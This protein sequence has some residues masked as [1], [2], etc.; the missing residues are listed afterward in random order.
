MLR[1]LATSFVSDTD[2]LPLPADKPAKW[3]QFDPLARRCYHAAFALFSRLPAACVDRVRT[4][5]VLLAPEGSDATNNAYFADYLENGRELGSGLLFRYTLPSCAPAEVAI[6]FGLQGPL[7]AERAPVSELPTVLPWLDA[8]ATVESLDAVLLLVA[9][10]GRVTGLLFRNEAE[11]DGTHLQTWD[12][13]QLPR[14]AAVVPCYNH[15]QTL[16]AIINDLYCRVPLVV[17]VDDGSNPPIDRTSLPDS[18]N[19]VLLRHASNQG[20]GAALLTAF[21]YLHREGYAWAVTLDAD[22]Q[23]AASDWAAFYQAIASVPSP[24]LWIGCREF[25]ENVPSSSRFGR[26]F[27]NFWVRLETGVSLHDTQSG[28]RA[29][30]LCFAE[31]LRQ[32]CATRRYD[33]EIESLV[34]LSQGGVPVRELPVSVFY[35]PPEKRVSHFDKFRDNARLSRLHTRLIFRR[36]LPFR[37]KRLVEEKRDPDALTIRDWLFH[38]LRVIRRLVT[39]HVT[40]LELAFSTFLG[41]FL[42]ALPIF[43]AHIVVIAYVTARFRMNQAVALSAQGLCTPP[44]LPVLCVELGHL[45]LRGKWLTDLAWATHPQAYLSRYGEWWIGSLV[46]GPILAI[47]LSLLVYAIA[48]AFRTKKRREHG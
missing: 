10:D 41:I 26:A 28:F 11:K 38:P 31:E 46:A 43:G 5:T 30:P 3:N 33:F 24:A 47:S 17:V 37:S 42:G 27:S 12:A 20:K 40:P 14:V 21:A 45:L 32:A 6:A 2:H 25:G 9:E 7:F 34:F 1:L 15:S 22:G 29:Y 48:T 4:A 39:D 13:W 44:F 18:P 8:M 19:V 16:P 35:E 23:H 36:L